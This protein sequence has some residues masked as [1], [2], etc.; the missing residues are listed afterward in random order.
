DT[1]S[2]GSEWVEIGGVR[3]HVMSY[4]GDFL[5]AP[6]RARSPVKSLSGAGAGFGAAAFGAACAGAAGCSTGFGAG[7]AGWRSIG[8]GFSSSICTGTSAGSGGVNAS[9]L[10]ISQNAA[11]V[12]STSTTTSAMPTR[13]QWR[14]KA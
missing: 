10:R 5:F 7:G 9:R 3:K 6:E 12:C 1:I 2:P 13:S 8:C 14:G 11:S 4:L